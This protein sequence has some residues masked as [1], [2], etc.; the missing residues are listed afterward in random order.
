M[1]VIRRKAQVTVSNN[2]RLAK[3]KPLSL[4]I[5]TSNGGR[6]INR[7]TRLVLEDVRSILSHSRTA[8][9]TEDR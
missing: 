7:M 6:R 1:K 4:H 5:T 3:E 9:A 2:G 8:G